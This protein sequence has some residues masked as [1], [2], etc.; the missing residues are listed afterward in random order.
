[1]PIISRFLGIT[2]YLNYSDH[3]PPHFD[4]RYAGCEPTVSIDPPGVRRGRLPP[5]VAGI[6]VEWAATRRVDL[7]EDWEL[8]RRHQP[9]RTIEPLE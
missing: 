6:V 9:L 8:A 5:R 4:V 2:V 7:L 1:M 3:S